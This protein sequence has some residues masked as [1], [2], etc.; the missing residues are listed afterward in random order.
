MDIE[1]RNEIVFNLLTL[2]VLQLLIKVCKEVNF[3]VLHFYN[4]IKYT[5]YSCKFAYY[6]VKEYR[7]LNNENDEKYYIIAIATLVVITLI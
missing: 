5:Y 6:S 2:S 7:Y 3:E 4:L 1:K